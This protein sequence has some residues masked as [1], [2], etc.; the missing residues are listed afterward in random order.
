MLRLTNS[1]LIEN[2]KRLAATAGWYEGVRKSY[3]GG[4]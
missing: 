1:A 2:Q 3:I 4:R